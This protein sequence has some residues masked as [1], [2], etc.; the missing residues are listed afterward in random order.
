MVLRDI[1]DAIIE[2]CASY[3]I[4][5]LDVNRYSGIYYNS[6]EDK[7][8]NLYF[9]DG[10]H[11]N[12][13]GHAKIA[14]IL[15]WYLLQNPSYV[16]GEEAVNYILSQF[17]GTTKLTYPNE[18]VV[19]SVEED[20]PTVANYTFTIN[21]TP[22]DA[23]VTINGTNTKSVTVASGTSVSWS[24]SADGYV[25]QSGTQTVTSETTKNIVLVAEETGGDEGG[26]GN[27]FT[28]LLNDKATYDVSTGVIGGTSAQTTSLISPNCATA[29]VNE[30][31]YDGMEVEVEAINSAGT[32]FAEANKV[33]WSIATLGLSIT[34][35]LADVTMNPYST[36]FPVG[37][38]NIYLDQPGSSQEY[39]VQYMKSNTSLGKVAL[40][41]DYLYPNG[42]T[43]M[44]IKVIFRKNADGRIEVK[45]GD[46]D[47]YAYSSNTTINALQQYQSGV[48]ADTVYFFAS[49]LGLTQVKVN[50]IGT[51][52]TPQGSDSG[53]VV[54]PTPNPDAGE[55]QA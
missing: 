8:T 4:P 17:S 34:N 22:T 15:H 24:V 54:N 5:V 25:A 23:V 45:V 11:P 47:W 39:A 42:D 43:V 1:C 53:G 31:I 13:A 50:Y 28:V 10:I 2:T 44:S 49:G 12:D 7:T 21:P 27:G 33:K 19:P 52:R 51:I 14:E 30:P 40:K 55:D 16:E 35:V 18:S 37:E 6:E 32:A 29:I 38:A 48:S 3:R 20:E 46:N 26:E 41:S 36:P 9:G